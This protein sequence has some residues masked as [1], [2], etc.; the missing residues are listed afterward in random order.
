MWVERRRISISNAAPVG[1][2]FRSW[3]GRLLDL[4]PGPALRRTRA[5]RA[6]ATFIGVE[7]PRPVSSLNAFAHAGEGATALDRRPAAFPAR[8]SAALGQGEV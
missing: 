8:S 6:T 4:T 3:R 2:R 1:W 5:H 7:G